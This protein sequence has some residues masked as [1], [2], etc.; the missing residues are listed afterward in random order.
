MEL[1]ISYLILC[2]LVGYMASG[3]TLGFVSG[4]LLSILLTPI[5]GFII[6]LLYPV[7]KA[8]Q[9]SINEQ[10]MQTKTPVQVAGK[11]PI[12]EVKEKLQKL[13]EMK[14][15]NLITESEYEELR[16]KALDSN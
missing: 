1:L 7:K 9:K 12:D 2:L 6:T 11:S 16:K 10:S 5:I 3:T 13:E 15:E 8:T 4:F 14:K